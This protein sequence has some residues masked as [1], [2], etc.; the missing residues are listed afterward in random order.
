MS[1][2]TNKSKVSKK[3]LLGIAALVVIVVAF[4]AIYA[5]FGAKGVAGNK[6]IT[7]EV[8]NKAQE[9]IVYEVSTDAEYLRGA[10]D[11]AEGLTYDGEEGQY[12]LAISAINGEVADFNVD[13]AY[14]SFYVN[15]EYCNYG[16]DEQ[17]IMDGDKFQIVYTV[18]E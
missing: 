15:G 10:M 5:V 6:N 14:W 17:P 8:I 1:E 4:L 9:S 2:T 16:I 3:G 12:G 11:E 18:M 13:S 7:I